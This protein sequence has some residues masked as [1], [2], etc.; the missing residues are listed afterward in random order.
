MYDICMNMN[1]SVTCGNH[2]LSLQVFNFSLYYIYYYSLPFVYMLLRVLGHYHLLR[3]CQKI[4]KKIFNL[5]EAEWKRVG[6]LA[7]PSSLKTSQPLDAGWLAQGLS[8]DNNG[9]VHVRW[10]QIL[11]FSQ[12]EN[13]FINS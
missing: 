1:I 10:L 8:R 6:S 7:M 13:G 2:V 12:V 5:F 3:R 4:L 9:S 11:K